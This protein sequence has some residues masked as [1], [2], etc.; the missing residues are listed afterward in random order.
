MHGMPALNVRLGSP[1]ANSAR[2]ISGL[3]KAKRVGRLMFTNHALESI[4]LYA[5]VDTRSEELAMVHSD[6]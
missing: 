1:A 4:K 5:R 2:S 6:W 3:R